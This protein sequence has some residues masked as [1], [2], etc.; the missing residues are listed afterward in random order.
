MPT[1]IETTVPG[2]ASCIDAL[3]PGY[4]QVVVDVVRREKSFSFAELGG[5]LP[6]IERSMID[7]FFT[8]D[9]DGTCPVCGKPRMASLDLRPEYPN[10]SGQDPLRLRNMTQDGK[11]RDLEMDALR[12]QA[13]MA[14]MRARLAELESRPRGPGRPRKTD[15]E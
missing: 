12:H 10:S 3:C 11:V 14:D 2:Y 5:D 4:E 13:E 6:G 1:V 8:S 7:P 15:D 9:E